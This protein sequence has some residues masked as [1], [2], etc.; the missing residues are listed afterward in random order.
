MSK[1]SKK[2]VLKGSCL[3]GILIFAL[4]IFIDQI[5]KIAAE[6]YL[7]GKDIPLFGGLVSLTLTHNPGIAYGIGSDASPTVKLAV[8][9]VT[10]VLMHSTI[11]FEYSVSVLVK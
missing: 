6:L 9:I 10:G 2:S 7:S 8:I 3:W 11:L 5:T 1:Q 4:L